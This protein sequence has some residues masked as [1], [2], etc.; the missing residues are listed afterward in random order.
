MFKKLKQTMSNLLHKAGLNQVLRKLNE[1]QEEVPLSPRL[2][3]LQ[4]RALENCKK[5]NGSRNQE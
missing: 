4:K 5:L 2:E 1:E 3:A